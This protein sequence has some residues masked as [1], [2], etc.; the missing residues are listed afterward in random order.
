MG[1]MPMSDDEIRQIITD[2]EE[3]IETARTRRDA[4]LRGAIDSGRRQRELVRITSMSRKA[5][6]QALNPEIREAVRRARAEK[7]K[8]K[9]D[10]SRS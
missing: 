3:D 1:R 10:D 7:R 8:Q 9:A 4:R 6:R 2:D 5:I